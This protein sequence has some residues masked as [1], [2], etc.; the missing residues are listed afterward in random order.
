LRNNCT[1]VR[2]KNGRIEINQY[3]ELK[4]QETIQKEDSEIIDDFKDLLFESVK[5]RLDNVTGT[6]LSGGIDSSSITAIASQFSEVKTFSHI[7]PANLLDKIYPFKDERDYINL[8]DDFCEIQDRYFISSENK[9]LIQALEENIIDYKGIT[10]QNFGV[11][12]DQLYRQV[13]KENTSVLLS[14]FGGDEIV[15]SK[16][17]GYLDELTTN[18]QW[19][20][21]KREI[22]SQETNR[23][24]Y[25]KTLLKYFLKIKTPFVYKLLTFTKNKRP[26]WIEKFENLAINK[27]FSEELKI[28]TRYFNYNN[29]PD[30]SSL[31]EKGISRITHPHVSQR[32]EYC[33]LIARKY[34]IEYRYPLLDIR[35]IEFYLSIPT[36]LKARNGIGRYAIRKAVEGIMPKE[37]QWRNDKSGATIPSVF[38]RML[39]DKEQI[40]DIINR[41]EKIESVKKYIDLEKYEQWFQKLC[42][43]SENKEKNVNPAA[44]Y[45]Y[46]KLI[47]FIEKNPSLFE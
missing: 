31:Q 22:K 42:R 27:T 10:Q 7:L 26:F 15:T 6:E 5:C 1:N 29:R 17:K 16:A 20:E 34:G 35:L 43:R 23:F 8:L 4:T 45:N 33:S 32:L 18:N 24:K 28:K 40:F 38:M 14:G 44:F 25:L 39:N 3:W 21:L 41:A 11:F 36:S 13:A 46:L 37:I 2:T 12:S 9:S 30:N 19:K 47:L